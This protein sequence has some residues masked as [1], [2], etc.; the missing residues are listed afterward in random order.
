MTEDQKTSN[1]A[2]SSSDST[3]KPTSATTAATSTVAP[4]EQWPDVVK[5]TYEPIRI[6]GKGGFASVMLAR[7]KYAN[8]EDPNK[9]VA[10]K[11]AGSKDLTKMELGYAHREIDIVRELSHPNIMKVIQAWTSDDDINKATKN[12]TNCAAVM[13]LSYAKGP[14]VQN[15]L[16]HGGA[17]SI[18]F[19]RVVIAQLVDALSY[20]HSRAVIHR[21]IK[22]VS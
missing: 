20:L 18:K 21:D 3:T 6:L 4:P 22:P 14:T 8:K 10:M 17:L 11:I 16:Q 7:N 13:A 19:G 5:E 12:T 1:T 15:L 9:L 2:N